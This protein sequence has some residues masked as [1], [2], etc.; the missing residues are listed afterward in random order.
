MCTRSGITRTVR[1]HV[2]CIFHTRGCPKIPGLRLR[3]VKGR[4]FIITKVS[5]APVQIVRKG[6]P[7]FN[8]HVNGVTCLASMGCLPRRRCTGLRNLSI[9][10]LATLHQKTRPARRSLRRTLIGVREVGPGRA[11]LVRVDRH[12]NL[13]TRMR[14]RLPPRIRLT[15]S[16]LRISA[17]LSR[18]LLFHG[19]CSHSYPAIMGH[20]FLG[21]LAD[22]L[23]VSSA[24]SAFNKE[25]EDDLFYI[26][27]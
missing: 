8:C 6:L 14:G 21:D 10:V 19:W 17:T 7:V 20:L 22:I 1:A 27:A 5:I 24:Y 9:L 26:G 18:D 23:R 25:G 3:Q 11:C 15:C 2:P 16:K 13:R 12:V 4:P